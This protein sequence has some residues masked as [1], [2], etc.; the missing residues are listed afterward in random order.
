[1]SMGFDF[2]IGRLHL[3]FDLGWLYIRAKINVAPKKKQH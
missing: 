2:H 1:M 3:G